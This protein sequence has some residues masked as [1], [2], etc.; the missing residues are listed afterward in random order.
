MA[1]KNRFGLWFPTDGRG[2]ALSIFRPAGMAAATEPFGTHQ[3]VY[4][5][6]VDGNFVAYDLEDAP[7]SGQPDVT[8]A[9]FQKAEINFLEKMA[10]RGQE[11]HCQKRYNP[12]A[13]VDNPTGWERIWHFTNGKI[14]ARTIPDGPMLRADGGLSEG[15]VTATFR[16][17]IDVVSLSLSAL[18]T[19]ET[20][21]ANCIDG[22][23]DIN[24]SC[25]GGY[26][27]ADKIMY[28]GCNADTGAPANVLFTPNGGGAWTATDNQPFGN[29]VHI[30][31]I[32]VR[33]TGNT[34]R[35]VAAPGS[36]GSN[37]IVAY[38]DET[39]GALGAGVW[40][41]VTVEAS[42]TS[43]TVT[44][45]RWLDFNRL[46]LGTSGGDIWV[47]EDQ[48]ESWTKIYDDGETAIYDFAIDRDGN[49]YACG[50]SSKILKESVLSRDTFSAKVGPTGGGSITK[51]AVANDGAILIGNGTGLYRSDNDAANAGGWS[52][53]KNFGS[54][55]S[56]IG[57]EFEG[58]NKLDG[59]ESELIRVFVTHSSN[60]GNVWET[61]DGGAS[62]RSITALPNTGYREVYASKF[63]NHY[64]IAGAASATPLATIHQ[65]AQ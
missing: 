52:V 18:N 8:F 35:V 27:G 62:F 56:V 60:G 49:V 31:K 48:A 26:P 59:G 36:V 3:V 54:G 2:S 41:T 47:S 6:G 9:F 29:D 64:V 28:I 11:I 12:C 32:Q 22:L 51:I 15:G 4:V 33:P 42:N 19:T 46:Y 30:N 50:A 16:T 58:K 17:V 39:L 44:A 7:P 37:L 1:T 5:N 38:M 20:E 43:D 45:L 10:N 24:V 61:V 53:R 57:L 14:N 23:K 63:G 21:H 34:F 13:S 25:A 65:L 55:Y 40:T